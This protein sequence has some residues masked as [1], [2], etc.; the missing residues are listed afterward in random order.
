M[1]E[2]YRKVICADGLEGMVIGAV[3]PILIT[4]DTPMDPD[5]WASKN[6]VAMPWVWKRDASGRII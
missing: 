3:D 5:Q 2:L 1:S 4:A 6:G